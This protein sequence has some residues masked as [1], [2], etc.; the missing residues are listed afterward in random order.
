LIIFGINGYNSGIKDGL[1]DIN[2]KNGTS[3]IRAGK[4]K[5]SLS[6]PPSKGGGREEH[7]KQADALPFPVI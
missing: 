7:P 3:I 1:K 2:I 6:L 5:V 4:I